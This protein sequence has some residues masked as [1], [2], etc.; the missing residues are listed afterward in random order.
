M[1][2]DNDSSFDVNALFGKATR[3]QIVDRTIPEVKKQEDVI[4]KQPKEEPKR[5]EP[6]QKIQRSIKKQETHN[7]VHQPKPKMVDIGS[8]KD[9]IHLKEMLAESISYDVLVDKIPVLVIAYFDALY[10]RTGMTIIADDKSINVTQIAYG[11]FYNEIDLREWISKMQE[12]FNRKTFVHFEVYTLNSAI[13]KTTFNAITN[14]I[15]VNKLEVGTLTYGHR[16]F[17]ILK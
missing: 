4:I 9:V 5:E 10:E 17:E 11:P 12:N 1:A 2:I 14:K 8:N 16:T 6:T 7:V 15:D 3:K 13:T